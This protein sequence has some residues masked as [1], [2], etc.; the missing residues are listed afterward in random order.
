[1]IKA[2][3]TAAVLGAGVAGLATAKTLKQ[4][5]FDVTVYE[6]RSELGGV[7]SNNYRSLRVLEP[8]WVYGYPDWPWPRETPLFPP[9][10]DVRNYLASYAEHF[11]IRNC[12]RLNSRIVEA[13]LTGDGQ[14]RIFAERNGERENADYD[15]FVIAPGMFNLK[16]TSDWPG[17]DTFEGQVIH[18]SEF[19]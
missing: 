19:S 14:W 12:I 9:A 6:A 15:Y 1:M 7:W 5:G 16:K 2:A 3:K 4:Y 18:S 11:G 17:Q 10:K 13:T 8:K